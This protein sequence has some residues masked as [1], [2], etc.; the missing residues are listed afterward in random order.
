[1]EK[2]LVPE[3]CDNLQKLQFSYSILMC[4]WLK[5]LQAVHNYREDMREARD[6]AR[7]EGNDDETFKQRISYLSHELE[8]VKSKLEQKN[9]KIEDLCTR[10]QNCEPDNIRLELDIT[11]LRAELERVKQEMSTLKLKNDELVKQI[12]DQ[13]R[14]G[15]ESKIEEAKRDHVASENRL[16]TLT[17]AY[18][19]S[20]S[21]ICGYVDAYNVLKREL[22]A[23]KI[24]FE[25]K[26][27]QHKVS[28]STMS[29]LAKQNIETAVLYKKQ[30]N[31]KNAE[32]ELLKQKI[33]P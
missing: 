14:I 16:Q 27:M 23:T 7:E 6:K 33:L 15:F 8:Y 2:L 20:Q 30:Y 11:D 28:Y 21:Q 3:D 9:E 1:M 32:L 24:D 26:V 29:A 25:K 13:K 22:E 5:G 4:E 17:E 31:D 19:N 10:L 12:E 18:K